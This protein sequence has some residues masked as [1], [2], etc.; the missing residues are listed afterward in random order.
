MFFLSFFKSK[1]DQLSKLFEIKTEDASFTRPPLARHRCPVCTQKVKSFDRLPDAY[2]DK[3]DEYGFIFS[4]FQFETL[5]CLRYLCPV[6]G[7]NDRDR[8]YALYLKNNAPKTCQSSKGSILDFAPPKRLQQFIR[9]SFPDFDYRSAD[10][11]RTDVDDRIDIS[12][13][14]KY[15]NGS[16]DFLLC[17]H[18]LEHVEQDKTAMKELFRILKPG[19]KG[20]VMVPI[21]L[22]LE[23]DYE[24]IGMVSPELRWKH[25]G[26]GDHVRMYSKSGFKQKLSCTGFKVHEF[27]I[28]YFGSE[29]FFQHGIHPRS[30]LYVIEKPYEA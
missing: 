3:L 19:G 12:N 2:Y 16:F 1:I 18:I 15:P 8:L 22:T 14:D 21:M 13:M 30:V 10:L 28:E 17:S 11:T 5:N 23:N 29:I 24:I 4:I 20:I 7:S 9:E 26:Q 6:C 27:S 25:F